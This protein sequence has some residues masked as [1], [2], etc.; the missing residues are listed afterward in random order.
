[1]L[2]TYRLDL[3][4]AKVL[5][6]LCCRAA[7]HFKPEYCTNELM[8]IRNYVNFKKVPG[9]KR[10]E[11]TIVG[12]VVFSKN[13]AHKDMATRVEQPH[14]LLLQ[15][16]IVYERIEGK[17]VSIST[18]LET[19]PADEI[20]NI[21]G[22]NLETNRQKNNEDEEVPQLRSVTTMATSK[23]R[24]SNVERKSEE[25][26]FTT[27][28]D[29]SADFQIPCDLLKQNAARELKQSATGCVSTAMTIG[30]VLL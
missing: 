14:I 16:P 13:V 10:I 25:K 28:T 29:V 24:Y 11:S 30:F 27:A 7:N 12:G 23:Q 1:M 19:S 18:V 4:W 21:D 17:F 22:T 9:G 8:D 5:N 2:R 6:P 20:I 15:C 26:V 3:Q